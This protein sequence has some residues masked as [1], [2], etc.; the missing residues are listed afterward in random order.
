MNLVVGSD[1]YIGSNIS[2]AVGRFNGG[3]VKELFVFK[4]KTLEI[5]A[6]SVD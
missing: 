3:S 1:S 5:K 6:E 2:E 4:Q